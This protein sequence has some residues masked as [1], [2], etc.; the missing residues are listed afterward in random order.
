MAK[1]KRATPKAKKTSTPTERD[2]NLGPYDGGPKLAAVLEENGLSTEEAA[3]VL[4]VPLAHFSL[5]MTGHMP[6][7]HPA[8]TKYRELASV[9][10]L[11]DLNIADVLEWHAADR[12]RWESTPG[13]SKVADAR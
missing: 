1:R 7:A 10:F 11:V 4:G 3:R 2:P 9:L 12:R 6:L 8:V 5:M 13:G